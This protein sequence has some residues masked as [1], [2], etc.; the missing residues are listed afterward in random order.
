MRHASRDYNGNVSYKRNGGITRNY[1]SSLFW[2]KSKFYN[3]VEHSR[4]EV[5]AIRLK[6]PN[7]LPVSFQCIS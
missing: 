2:P 6:F 1:F 5:L 4:D 3:C 7:K